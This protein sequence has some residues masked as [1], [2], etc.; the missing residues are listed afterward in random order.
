[1]EA[2]S[3]TRR[4]GVSARTAAASSSVMMMVCCTVVAASAFPICAEQTIYLASQ[5]FHPGFADNLLWL[6][7]SHHGVPLAWC[8]AP[9]LMMAWLAKAGAFRSSAAW[10]VRH[11]GF[12][13][14][15]AEDIA[16][17]V[18]GSSVFSL[19]EIASGCAAAALCS[20][21]PAD[22]GPHGIFAAV[23][24][25]TFP[26]KPPS[27]FA[28]V[29][30]CWAVSFLALLAF[31]SLFQLGRSVLPSAIVPFVVL[32][33]IGLP[34]VHGPQSGVIDMARAM[35]VPVDTAGIANPLS[36]PFE[37]ASVFYPS[38]LPGAGHGLWILALV[39]GAAVFCGIA[40]A[41]RRE[42]LSSTWK[43]SMFPRA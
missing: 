11:P 28:I 24:G 42:L 17:V 4:L 16:D 20:N 3:S 32:T 5:G 29:G 18:V 12:R 13:S 30:S 22:F 31:G 7:S 1:M 10:A 25:S 9:A 21:G 40:T 38:W 37:M 8:V 41:A 39:A 19:A 35:G 23:V 15:W 6:F 33:L 27:L 26:G 2:R 34:N 14:L 36:I 43:S